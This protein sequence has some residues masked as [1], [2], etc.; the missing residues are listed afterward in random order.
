[1]IY[2]LDTDTLI[3]MIRGSK[4]PGSDEKHRRAARIEAECQVQQQLGNEVGLSAIT[5]AELEYGARLSSHYDSEIAAV[6]KILL[7]FKAFDFDCV[8]S[9]QQYGDVRE[10]LEAAGTPIGSM[11]LLIAAHARALGAT[12]ITN[13]AAHFRRVRDLKCENWSA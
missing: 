12:L 3:Y 6:R 7:P 11:D 9:A 1:M 4:R 10:T 5:I 13:N 2:L 8:A